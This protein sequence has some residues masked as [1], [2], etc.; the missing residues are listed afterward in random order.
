MPS[1]PE[2]THGHLLDGRVR[3]TQPAS[4]FRSGIEPVLLAAAVPARPGARVLEGGSGAGATLL[5]LTARVPGA[6][7]L[8]IEQDA[9]LVALARANAAANGFSNLG[10]VA[11]DIASTPPPGEFDHAC[12]NPPYHAGG[13][14]P[15]PDASRRAAKSAAAGL[16]ATWA[17]ALARSLRPHGTL[18]FVLPAKLL[19]EAATAFAD[20]GCRPVSCLPLWPKPGQAAKLVLLRGVKGSRGPF[21]LLPGLVLHEPS[22]GFTAEA[23][24]ILRCGAALDL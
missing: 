1:A 19:P 20:A 13:G 18:T 5:C 7:G 22:G 16:P 3:Y 8:G 10:F 4:G 21:R 6:Q 9:A 23:E 15:S 12:A 14:T 11:A 2:Q 17:A 24:A